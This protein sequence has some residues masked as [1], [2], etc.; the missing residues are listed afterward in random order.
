MKTV[1]RTFQGSAEFFITMQEDMLMLE[2]VQVTAKQ[3]I[4]E[5]DVRAKREM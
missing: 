2:G 4:N 5:I 3:N 1:K